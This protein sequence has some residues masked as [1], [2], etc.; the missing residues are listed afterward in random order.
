MS[1]PP[2]A[3]VDS[4]PRAA[5]ATA[6]A[7]AQIDELQRRLDAVPAP[8]EPLDVVALDGY[9]CG[10][11][12]QPRPVPEARWMRH[13]FDVEGRALPATFDAA[14][15]LALIRRRHAELDRAIGARQWFDP[16]VFELEDDARVPD[17]PTAEDFESASAAVYPWIVG[18]ATA[19]ELFPAL[20]DRASS[21]LTLP[22]ALLYR[23]LAPDDLEDADDVL[24][25]I[26]QIGPA[27]DLAEAVEGLVRATLLLA[28][29]GRPLRPSGASR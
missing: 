20:T 8:L 4:S 3:P 27:A 25:E 26:E 18:F 7:A 10:V 16:W 11:L 6:L 21:E 14:A 9:L 24:A 29:I 1:G 13:V 2:A 17:E 23:H 28:D 19:A 22:L 12:V 15:L 5:P